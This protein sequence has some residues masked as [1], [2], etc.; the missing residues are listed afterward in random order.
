MKDLRFNPLLKQ[1]LTSYVMT[2]Y[3]ENYDICEDALMMEYNYMKANNIIHELFDQEY[4]DH[5]LPPLPAL[6]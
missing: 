1:L 4:L 6:P 3:E 5:S 2:M